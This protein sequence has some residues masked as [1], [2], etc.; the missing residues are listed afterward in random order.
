MKVG[1]TFLHSITGRKKVTS[2][3]NKL[4][5]ASHSV[6]WPDFLLSQ[7]L[8]HFPQSAQCSS[9]SSCS[10]VSAGTSRSEFLNQHPGKQKILITHQIR[11]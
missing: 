6:L 8:S 1:F 9:S 5:L 7:Q 4:G 3:S 10:P 11:R 2:H